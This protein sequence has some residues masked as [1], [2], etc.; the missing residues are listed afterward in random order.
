MATN[1]RFKSFALILSLLMT[2][3]ML[4]HGINAQAGGKNLEGGWIGKDTLVNTDSIYLY[5]GEDEGLASLSE[6]VRFKRL[7][8]VQ[9]WARIDSLSGANSGLLSIQASGKRSRPTE[10]DRS[11]ITIA[12]QTV[13]I[14]G[15]AAQFITFE[16]NIFTPHWLRIVASR[17]SGTAQSSVEGWAAIK[18][19]YK[20]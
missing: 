16:D 18:E 5:V 13:T 1:G 9:V 17:T 12:S 15:T 11:W 7:N 10:T 8:S 19:A 6:A 20:H 14:D 2:L 4:P 3:F